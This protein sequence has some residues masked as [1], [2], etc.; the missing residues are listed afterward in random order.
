MGDI[1]LLETQRKREH[2]EESQWEHSSGCNREGSLT[3]S[4][5]FQVELCPLQ[6]R[7]LPLGVVF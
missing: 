7:S 5:V 3:L 4:S 2:R 1:V 6:A